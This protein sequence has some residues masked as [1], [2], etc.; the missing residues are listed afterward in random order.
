MIITPRVIHLSTNL[1]SGMLRAARATAAA[2]HDG[3][4]HWVHVHAVLGSFLGVNEFVSVRKAN[5]GQNQGSAQ[6]CCVSVRSATAELRCVPPA[7]GVPATGA[8][9]VPGFLAQNLEGFEVVLTVRW[10]GRR[11]DAGSSTSCSGGG[12]GT[13][14]EDGAAA[15]RLRAC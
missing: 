3:A 2:L 12:A 1:G 7:T 15:G 13:E 6:L 14:L 8:A 10:I 11:C 5:A 4:H 9:H